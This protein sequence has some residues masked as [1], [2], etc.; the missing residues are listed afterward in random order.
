MLRGLVE[1]T[2]RVYDEKLQVEELECM[3]HGAAACR[4]LVRFP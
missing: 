1:G 4:F 3:H 2:G